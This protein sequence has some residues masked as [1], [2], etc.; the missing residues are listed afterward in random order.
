M[1]SGVHGEMVAGE[2]IRPTESGGEKKVVRAG[3]RKKGITLTGGR[4]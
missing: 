4:T 1:K 2:K 3:R